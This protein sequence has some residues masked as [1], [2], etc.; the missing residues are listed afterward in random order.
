ME[1][2]HQLFVQPTITTATL[3]IIGA[4]DYT[5]ICHMLLI[6]RITEGIVKI[7]N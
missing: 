4:K 3:P 2:D 7:C 5:N 1:R 6:V